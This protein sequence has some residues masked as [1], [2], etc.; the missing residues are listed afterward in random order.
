MSIDVDLRRKQNKLKNMKINQKGIYLVFSV[1]LG[2]TFSLNV[3]AA[4]PPIVNAGPDLYVQQN[5]SVILQGTASDPQNSTLTCF[6]NCSGGTLSS[7]SIMQPTFTAPNLTGQNTYNC[8]FTVTNTYGLSATDT[9]MVIVNPTG[10]Q[11]FSVQTNSATSVSNNQ[12]TLNG[13]FSGSNASTNYVYFQWG[14]TSAYGNSTN[15]FAQSG[16]T[17]SFSQTI[18]GLTP[19]AV[20]HYRAVVQNSNGTVYGSDSTFNSNGSANYYSNGILS[21]NKQVINLASGNLN[22]SSSVNANEGDV[23]SF[24]ITLQAGSQEIHNVIV[25]DIL[26]AGLVFTGNLTINASLSNGNPSNSITIGTIP[27]NGISVIAYQARVVNNGYGTNVLTNQAT[28]TSSEGGSQ[29]ASATVIV[30]NSAVYGVTDYSTGSTNNPLTD[31]FLFPMALIVLMSWLYFTGRIYQ[32]A[33]WVGAK[34]K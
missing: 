8:S 6:W 21:V 18:T 29:I 33:D 14:T 31:S 17:S 34:I 30:T 20:Y 13:Y 26:P 16:S 3:L 5:Q 9:M 22:W 11:L 15:Q 19:N 1:L 24:A 28:V 23:L 7:T 2:L 12:A 4:N 25:R 32:F 27:A 10:S